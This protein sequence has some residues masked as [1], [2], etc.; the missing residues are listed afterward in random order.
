MNKDEKIVLDAVIEDV[1]NNKAFHARLRNGHR[2]V[3]FMRGAPVTP[4]WAPGD[5]VDVELSPFDFSKG[6]VRGR[7][8]KEAET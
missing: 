5:R 1:I 4:A 3:A 7:A 2:L 6:L 8:S